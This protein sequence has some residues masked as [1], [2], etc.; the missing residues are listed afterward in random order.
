MQDDSLKGGVSSHDRLVAAAARTIASRGYRDLTVEHLVRV[1]GVSRASFYQHFPNI[2][3]CFLS[4]HHVAAERLAAHVA[5]AVRREG[6]AELAAL[7]ALLD[8]ALQRPEDARLAMHEALAAGPPALLARDALIARI[9]QAIESA[10]PQGAR[11]DLPPALLVGG[12]MRFLSM[13][14]Q[15][16]ALDASVGEELLAWAGACSRAAE[17]LWS[18]HFTPALA[19]KSTARGQLPRIAGGASARERILGATA[20]VVW[21][22]G[23][24]AASVADIAATAGV[25]RRRFYDEFPDKAAAFEAAH[26]RMFAVAMAACAPAFFSATCWQERVWNSADAL[27]LTF[28]RE[29]ALAHLGFVECDAL[30]RRFADRVRE[31][32]LAFTWFLQEDYR[33]AGASPARAASA[34]LTL[35]TILEACFHACRGGVAL[36][37]RR[38]HPLIVYIALAPVAGPERAGRFIDAKL[39][40]RPRVSRAGQVYTASTASARIIRQTSSV[41]G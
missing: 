25:S 41:G 3:S 10:R 35:T 2:E 24:G 28:S 23:Y 39:R 15:E 6:N 9:T 20:A 1:A 7:R 27:T 5:A 21:A 13:R 36:Q 14:M 37:L 18:P 31:T 32:Q 40:A 19:A 17:H 34:T 38:V 30:G 26:E 29:P 11:I 4:A 22:K 8:F 12:V 16:D 33:H